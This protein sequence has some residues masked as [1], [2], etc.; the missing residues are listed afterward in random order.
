MIHKSIVLIVVE[1]RQLSYFAAVARHRH[2]TR[3]AEEIRIAQPALSQQVRRLEAELG[4]ELLRRTTRRV[5]LTE[6]GELLLERANR[7][8]QEVE[9]AR[10][11]LSELSGLLRGHVSLGSLPLASLGVPA[12]LEAFRELYPGVGMH[13]HEQAID[14]ILNLL[15][16]DEL[17]LAFAMAGPGQVGPEMTARILYEEELVAV[18]STG[19]ALAGRTAVRVEELAADA[20][21][22]FR[23][24]SALRRAVDERLERA[25]PAPEYAFE[26]FELETIRSLASH[27]LGVALL[28]AGYLHPAGPRVASAH[29]RPRVKL[30]VSLVWRTDRRQTPAAE[31]FLEFALERF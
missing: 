20:L 1:L 8:L 22:G 5:E 14:V 23:P 7:I 12:M 6:A 9:A 3:A 21:I 15:R 29:M 31:A 24:G 2:F 18:M 27:G 11:E 28:P 19:H 26:T 30:P 13:L 16:R 17:D 4:I 10:Q 25:D